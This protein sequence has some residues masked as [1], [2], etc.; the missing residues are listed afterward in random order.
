LANNLTLTFN[1]NIIGA[2]QQHQP[3]ELFFDKE[4]LQ[5][6][7]TNLLSNAVKFTSQNGKIAVEVKEEKKQEDNTSG[8]VSVKVSNTG[9]GI[10]EDKLAFVFDRFFQVDAV[11]E[12]R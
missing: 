10:P 5:K 4:K 2:Q 7:I 1:G 9:E 8:M 6:I 11:V 12:H 3:I